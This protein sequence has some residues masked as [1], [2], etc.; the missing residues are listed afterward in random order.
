[1]TSDNQLSRQRR[2]R[3]SDWGCLAEE[4]SRM[5]QAPDL[6]QVTVLTKAQWLRVQDEL[7]QVDEEKERLREVANQ[8]LAL[9]LKSKEVVKLWSNTITGQREKKLEAKKIREELEEEKRKQIDVEEAQFKEQQRKEAI[10]KAKTQL[11]YQTDRVRGFHSA[12]MLTEVLKEREAQI[13]LK[14]RINSASK[15]VDQEFRDM[16]KTRG[17]EALRREQEK[18]LQKKLERLAAAEDVKKQIKEKELT[19]E[20]Q[21]TEHKKVEEEILRLGELYQW[22]LREKE[23]RRAEQKTSLMQAHLEHVT[24]RDLIRAAEAQKHEAKGEQGK[25]FPRLPSFSVSQRQKEFRE[26]LN[27]RERIMNEMTIEHQEQ[28]VSEE[29]RIAQAVAEQD[30]RWERQR[31]EEEERRAAM[32][33]TITAHRQL[34]RQKK[35]QMDK[36]VQQR[37]R[38][39]HQANKEADRSFTETQQLKAQRTRED[40]TKIRDFNVT[41]KEAK[42]A[43]DHQ[44]RRG[45]HELEAKNRDLV[46]GEEMQ[47]QQYS[48]HVIS[49]AAQTQRNVVPLCKAAREG[50]GIGLG[51]IISGVRPSYLV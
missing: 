49:A 18:A 39:V 23:E 14:K 34:M 33:K 9:S 15:D 51:P 46:D 32:L 25:P 29:Q 4:T 35:E 21:K 2:S 36:E 26:A 6:R 37:D 13:E 5:F 43:R 30:A 47:F 45:D 42:Y 31:R 17:D 44:L 3:K 50:V 11:Y 22:E 10:E 40:L 27:R 28:T 1:M 8:R 41:Q 48:Q 24:N 12:L 19:R 7:N 20:R 16:G 38:D